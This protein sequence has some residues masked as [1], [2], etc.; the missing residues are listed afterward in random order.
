MD[1]LYR[2][3]TRYPGKGKLAFWKSV[4]E[5][6]SHVEPTYNIKDIL[7]VFMLFL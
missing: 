7:K 6:L 4:L 1:A 3:G 5:K 2:H